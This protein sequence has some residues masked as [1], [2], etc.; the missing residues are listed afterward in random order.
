[1]ARAARPRGGTRAALRFAAAGRAFT[2]RA[3]AARPV[4]PLRAGL[5]R[6][7]SSSLIALPSS[8]GDFTVR[9]PAAANAAYLSAAVPLPPAT[10]APACPMRFPGGGVAPATYATTGLGTK[11]GV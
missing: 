10:M 1:P 8:A 4:A 11:R 3:G 7:R 6:P 2:G 9:T 5:G